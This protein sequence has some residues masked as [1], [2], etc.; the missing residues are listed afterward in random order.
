MHP[1]EQHLKN[2]FTLWANAW[3][4]NETVEAFQQ[5]NWFVFVMTST[6]AALLAAYS[7]FVIKTRK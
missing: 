6:F 3:S 5:G 4:L 7:F 2:L 1:T